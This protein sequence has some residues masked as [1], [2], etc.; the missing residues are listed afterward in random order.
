MEIKDG[1][2]IHCYQDS[3]FINDTEERY[4]LCIYKRKHFDDED[5]P[6]CSANNAISGGNKFSC[7]CWCVNFPISKKVPDRDANVKL[8]VVTTY[9]NVVCK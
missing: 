5:Q 6:M 8:F 7:S 9:N 1:T 3:S 2:V 4:M